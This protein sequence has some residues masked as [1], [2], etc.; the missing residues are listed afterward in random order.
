MKSVRIQSFSGPYFPAFGRNTEHLCVQS[1]CRKIWTR[2]ISKYG[3]ISRSVGLFHVKKPLQSTFLSHEPVK[4]CKRLIDDFRVTVTIFCKLW[5]NIYK[6]LL[7]SLRCGTT[8]VKNCTDLTKKLKVKYL[9]STL[10]S[11]VNFHIYAKESRNKG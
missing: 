4:T 6:M 10:S 11:G 1:E 2:K 8:F 7:S 9:F 5:L 3:Q